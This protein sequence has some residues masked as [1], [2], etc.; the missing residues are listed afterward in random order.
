MLR[1]SDRTF[2]E[3]G[4]GHH[5]TAG[6]RALRRELELLGHG[7]VRPRRRGRPVPG[8]AIGVHERV[9]DLSDSPM[10]ASPVRHRRPLIDG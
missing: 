3:G 2:E 4:S 7:L 6:L 9:G 10:N 5:A 1:Q 8:P